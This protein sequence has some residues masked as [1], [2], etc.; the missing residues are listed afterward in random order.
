MSERVKDIV[1]LAIDD[2][3]NK[4]SSLFSDEMIDRIAPAIDTAKAVVSNELFG[5]D[6]I[7]PDSQQDED[8]ELHT[9]EIVDVDETEDS[10]DTE[11]SESDELDDEWEDEDPE[12]AV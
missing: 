7:E 6:Y 4:A 3:P 1:S 5:Q 9:Q 12:E 2:K 11:D 8:E 10:D